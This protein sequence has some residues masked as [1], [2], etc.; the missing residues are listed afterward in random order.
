MNPTVIPYSE[1]LTILTALV[2]TGTPGGPWNGATTHLY[3]NNFVPVP[4]MDLTS[5]V[6]ADFTGYAAGSAVTWGT[7]GFLP[8]GPAVVT[9]NLQT[10]TVGAT[11]TVFNTIYGYYMVDVAG[12]GLL[13]ARQF[14]API[15]LSG[16]AQIIDVIPSYV[17]Y[18]SR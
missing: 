3:K 10:F 1:W 11:P 15:V 9:G 4:G 5:L 6:E 17:T 13:F 18:L 16:P 7:P 8:G 12:T 14:D 2:A